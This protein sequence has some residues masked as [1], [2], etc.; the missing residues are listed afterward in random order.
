MCNL[1]FIVTPRL[2]AVA[3]EEIRVLSREITGSRHR[4]ESLGMISMSV[5][6]GLS[7]SSWTAI[8]KDL[9]MPWANIFQQNITHSIIL[10]HQASHFPIMHYSAISSQGMQSTCNPYIHMMKKI[11]RP[12]IGHL[13][14]LHDGPALMPIR[15]AFV[16]VL[17]SAVALW[18][19]CS[20]AAQ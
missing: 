11:Y 4:G 13:L 6:L 10:P 3:E 12:D 16:A 8:H 17:G 20:Y 5:L 2:H 14:T 18:P 15:A 1:L 19:V 9:R 7:F